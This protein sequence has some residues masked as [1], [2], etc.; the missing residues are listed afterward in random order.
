MKQSKYINKYDY[1]S[2]YTKPKGLWFF[3]NSEIQSAIE[4]ELKKLSNKKYIDHDDFNSDID[5][6]ESDGEI[7][8]YEIYKERLDENKLLDD[9]NPQIIQGKII[10]EKSRNFILQKYSHILKNVDLEKEFLTRNNEI[11]AEKTKNLLL[12]N[13]EIILFQSVFIYDNLITKPDAIIKTKDELIV[14]ETK[15]TTSSK[16]IHYLDM[17]FQMQVIEKQKY[18]KELNLIYDYFLCLIEYCFLNKNNI[19]FELVDTINLKKTVSIPTQHKM[20]DSLNQM[21]IINFKNGIKKGYLSFNEYFEPLKIKKLM[22]DDF[23]VLKQNIECSKGVSKISMQKS[24]DN[25]KKINLNF[26]DAIKDLLNHKKMMSKDS[27]PYFAPSANDKS[28]YKNCDFFPSERKIY[29]Y[30]GY[31]IFDYSGNVSNQTDL[32]L[33]NAKINDYLDNFIKKPSKNPF[34]FKNLFSN[35]NT[36]LINKNLCLEMLESLSNK[37]VYF[38]FETIN[39]P[40]RVV[41]NSLP[42]MQVVTQCSIIKYDRET[43]K[44][45]DV[46]CQNLIVDPL[47]IEQQWF[48]DVVDGIYWETEDNVSYIV[49]NKSFEK[50]RLQEINKIINER[51]YSFKIEKIINGLFDL[52]DFFKI[53]AESPSYILFFKELGGFY[54]I[55]KILPL[56]DK[57]CPNIYMD[58]KCLDYN[59]LEISNGQ[60]CQSET[61]KRFFKIIDDKSWLDVEK[62]MQIYCENDVR[63]MIAVE[64]FINFFINQN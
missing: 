41:D 53:K 38:D 25:L 10:D 17:F 33:E 60:I 61:V 27:M 7:D 32:Y 28:P 15:G 43:N 62:N 19:S 22:Y 12:E 37:K 31:N 49:Y 36:Y 48:K 16:F 34:V 35:P 1:M 30:L 24:F 29:S 9:N 40:I 54:S 57:Y 46:F 23:S 39:T 44:L 47:K 14:I 8:Y 21:E 3:S 51:E 13:K 11:L 63:A 45:D 18:L 42:F 52:A 56:I 5:D 6:F 20:Y 59:E 4:V 50:T 55:K 2:Y 58:T 26:D 64:Y